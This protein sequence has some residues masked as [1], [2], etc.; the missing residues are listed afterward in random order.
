MTLLLAYHGGE[1]IL[2]AADKFS[3]NATNDVLDSLMDNRLILNSE[4]FARFVEVT[5]RNSDIKILQIDEFKAVMVGGT[6]RLKLSTED[7]FN[8]EKLVSKLKTIKQHDHLTV[9]YGEYQK[10]NDRCILTRIVYHN[11]LISE[12]P[13]NFNNVG[14][15]DFSEEIENV[16]FTEFH[17]KFYDAQTIKDKVKVLNDFYNR[18]SNLYHSLVD[19]TPAIAVIDKEG[20]R[21]LQGNKESNVY[22][23]TRDTWSTKDEQVNINSTQ[24]VTATCTEWFGIGSTQVFDAIPQLAHRFLEVSIEGKVNVSGS[25]TVRGQVR[26]GFSSDGGSNY[27]WFNGPDF[28]ETS[29]TRKNWAFDYTGPKNTQILVN[30]EFRLC[31]DIGDGNMNEF[32]VRNPII[33]KRSAYTYR[34]ELP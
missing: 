29:W 25:A 22:I 9:Y 30:F 16:F 31:V 19:G 7:L 12:Q 28:T 18:I 11:G 32:Y 33:E 5:G 24:K 27:T 20:F 10:E 15:F 8:Q 3:Y 13:F 21:L 1:Y 14:L 34:D 17:S 23:G 26:V 2:F 6:G 4:N